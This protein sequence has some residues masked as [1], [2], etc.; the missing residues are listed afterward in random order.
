MLVVIYVKCRK[1]GL[2]AECLGAIRPEFAFF[3]FIT[4]SVAKVTSVFL[5]KYFWIV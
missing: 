4:D 3:F 1:I 5:G 2:Y